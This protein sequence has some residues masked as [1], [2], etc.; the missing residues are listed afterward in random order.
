MENYETLIKLLAIYGALWAANTIIATR[1]N[2]ASGF[3]WDWTYFRNGV[4]KAALGGFGL[5]VGAV[6]INYIPSVFATAGIVID[7]ATASAIS[8]LGVVGAIGSGI[9][10]YAKKF[11]SSMTSLFG[12]DDSISMKLKLDPND[13][14]HGSV[15]IETIT[16]DKTDQ[17]VEA[18]AGETR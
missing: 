9:A 1:N 16:G 11:V 2:L 18:A 10:V 8:L 5:A 14:N 3:S 13:F 7:P 17:E 12:S 4:V 6:A 15:S